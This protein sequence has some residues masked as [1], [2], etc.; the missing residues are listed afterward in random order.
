MTMSRKD[1]FELSY[2]A[3]MHRP[4]RNSSERY[5]R[6]AQQG[7]LERTEQGYVITP[8]GRQALEDEGKK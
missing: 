7:Y 4:V 8:A 2:V 5:K 3:V 6:L 1:Y